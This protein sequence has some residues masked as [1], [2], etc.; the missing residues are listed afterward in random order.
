VERPGGDAVTVFDVGAGSNAA[1]AL[2][3][4][5]AAPSG[6]AHLEL[7]SFERDLVRANGR[8]LSIGRPGQPGD[9][10]YR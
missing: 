3:A 9:P 7:V 4:A 2:R 1:A 10:P 5:W 8:S 6:A